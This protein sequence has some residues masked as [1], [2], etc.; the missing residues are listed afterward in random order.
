MQLTARVSLVSPVGAVGSAV[1]EAA[2]FDALG[3]RLLPLRPIARAGVGTVELVLG[4]RDGRAVAL[5]GAV[6]A[7]L[8]AVAA[9]PRWG[10]KEQI[11]HHRSTA[12]QQGKFISKRLSQSRTLAPPGHRH[13]F[14]ATS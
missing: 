10:R 11:K 7:V 8:V 6:G 1:T 3:R 4:A 13:E 12:T 9:P 14:H 2:L 5:V